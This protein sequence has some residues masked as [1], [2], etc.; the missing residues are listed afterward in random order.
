MTSATTRLPH[1]IALDLETTFK[2]IVGSSEY[3][4]RRNNQP[5]ISAFARAAEALC[6]LETSESGYRSPLG[7]TYEVVSTIQVFADASRRLAHLRMQKL[8][9]RDE[10][11]AQLDKIIP[12]NHA[13]RAMIERNPRTKL[14]EFYQF[15]VEMY[16]VTNRQQWHRDRKSAEWC[17]AEMSRFSDEVDAILRSMRQE[18]SVEQL[19]YELGYDCDTDVSVKEEEAEID[20]FI[21]DTRSGG[22]VPYD[23]KTSEAAAK[24][25][26][27][28]DS[29]WGNN[30]LILTSGA[31]DLDFCGGS[32]LPS[33]A[34]TRLAP[35]FQKSLRLELSRVL[36][37]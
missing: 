35:Q 31:T 22:W 37:K 3:E 33:D 4:D 12:F 28:E 26:R 32:R 20:G 23:A 6:V 30:R 2:S 14:N 29:A 13:V 9:T 10:R 19:L 16:V 8:T 36:K 1:P 7:V 18:I 15:I 34:V 27:S 21:K 25:A 11:T 17:S 5:P 24:E